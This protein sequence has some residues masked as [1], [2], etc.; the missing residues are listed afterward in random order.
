MKHRLIVLGIGA[1]AC[2]IAAGCAWFMQAANL[3][4]PQRAV[5]TDVI[6]LAARIGC[7]Q[8]TGGAR[9][10]TQR[11]VLALNAALEMSPGQGVTR[12]LGA[13]GAD[14]FYGLAWQVMNAGLAVAPYCPWPPATPTPT[15]CAGY[16]NLLPVAL[17]AFLDGC[18]GGLG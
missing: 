12:A 3:G 15:A 4:T 2:C 16:M 14:D 11:E 17:R 6:T 1:A 9:E 8:F 18:A 10:S 5:F 13:Q 7:A